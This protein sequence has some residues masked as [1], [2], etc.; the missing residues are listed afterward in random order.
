MRTAASASLSPNP[1]LPM[2]FST[3]AMYTLAALA[4]QDVTQQAIAG[5][6]PLPASSS[7]GDD[8]AAAPDAVDVAVV[9]PLAPPEMMI[10]SPYGKSAMPVSPVNPES[11]LQLEQQYL[12]DIDAVEDLPPAAGAS[13]LLPAPALSAPVPQGAETAPI[14]PSPRLDPAPETA[15]PS[16]PSTMAPSVPASLNPLPTF[17]WSEEALALENT[18][19]QAAMLPADGNATPEWATATAAPPVAAAPLSD[20][21][22]HWSAPFV[23]ALAAEQIVQGFY[24]DRSFRPDV[25]VTRAEFAAMIRRAFPQAV[26]RSPAPFI[27][28]PADHWGREAIDLAYQ[29]GFLVGYPGQRFAPDQTISRVEAVMAM[30]RGLRMMASADAMQA[31]SSAYQDAATIP[32]YARNAVAAATENRLVINYPDPSLMQAERSATRGE[33]AALIYQALVYQ[34]RLPMIESGA[35]ARTSV[36]SPVSSAALLL[37][38]SAAVAAPSPLPDPTQRLRLRFVMEPARE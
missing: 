11:L 10:Q 38:P 27:D 1:S 30:S 18:L 6:A 35:A 33:A 3:A 19:I 24:E 29:M 26:V 34:G 22:G 23:T 32:P 16:R 5:P 37:A 31:L 8:V 13:E 2:R 36:S 20:A 7:Q 15:Q 9:E 14:L 12:T 25:P 17:T 28:V 21:Q 4:A